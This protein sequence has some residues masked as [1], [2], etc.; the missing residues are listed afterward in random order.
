MILISGNDGNRPERSGK[1]AFYGRKVPEIDG[2][3]KQ[4]SGIAESSGSFPS[5]RTG[6]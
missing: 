5:G 2:K 4:Y 6:I 3:R 1:I